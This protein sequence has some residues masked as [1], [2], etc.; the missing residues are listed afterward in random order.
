MIRMASRVPLRQ[1][2][3]LVP[4]RCVCVCVCVCVY[5]FFLHQHPEA[6]GIASMVP[7]RHNDRSSAAL[8]ACVVLCLLRTPAPFMRTNFER[9]L[10][11]LAEGRAASIVTSFFEKRSPV[12]RDVEGEGLER[13]LFISS[14]KMRLN[15][16]F[17]PSLA[18]LL[19][20]QNLKVNY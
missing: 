14:D 6:L 16:H 15:I 13:S 10:K 11:F 18:K 4:V 3:L 17:L 1:P 19:P 9:I 20:C 7:Q 8:A 2:S 12:E 5:H